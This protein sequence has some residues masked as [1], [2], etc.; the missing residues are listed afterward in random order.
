MQALLQRV[1]DAGATATF[2][3]HAHMYERINYLL[4]TFIV[5]TGGAGLYDVGTVVQNSMRRLVKYGYLRV[6]CGP[7]RS[8]F[9]FKD[10]SG[11]V[12]DLFVA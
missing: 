6:T 9:E 12:L 8:V 10:S 3:G 7:L 2:H 4:P 5:G 11:V 1:A